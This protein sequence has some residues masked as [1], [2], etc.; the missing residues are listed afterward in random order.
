[1]GLA[2]E[3]S[4]EMVVGLLA[5][6]ESRWSVRAA[7]PDATRPSAWRTWSRTARSALLLTHSGV[8]DCMEAREGLR[9]LEL[10][11]LD[12]SG[13]PATNPGMAVHA[14]NLAYVIYTPARRA[15][16]GRAAA[17]PSV[18]RCWRATAI[19]V[20]LRPEDVWTLFHLLRVRLLGWEI[21]GALCTGG[22]L[23][24]V[25]YWVSRS[26]D[27]FLA[28][29]RS[30]KVTVLNQTPSAFGRPRSR[31]RAGEGERGARRV[32]DLRRRG[33]GAESLRPWIERYGDAS[34]RLVNMYGI[35][36][37]TVHVTYRPITR[38]D[39]RE[40]GS[41]IPWASPFPT[42]RHARAGRRAQPGAGGRGG[43]G[44][45]WRRGGWRAAIWQPGGADARSA[46]SRTRSGG[47]ASG[48][49][50][51]ET[52]CAGGNDGRAGVPG[53]ASTIR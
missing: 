32:R 47:R 20:R 43:R 13:E 37:T 11:T 51:R 21:F 45:T 8:R 24:V 23:V 49:T 25:P 36:E 53:H 44:C 30:Q 50:A 18:A 29:L 19:V 5:I 4:L 40:G 3:R 33:A 48:C 31:H 27:D 17:P 6:L 10:D 1:M 42:L 28:L 46:S 16:Q 22:R 2:V 35:T 38:A 15:A 52:W 9:V 14:D 26:P 41:A 12:V 7:G 34:P 39:L